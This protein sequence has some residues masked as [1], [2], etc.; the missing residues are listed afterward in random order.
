MTT[1]VGSTEREI[2]QYDLFL[3]SCRNFMRTC[4][5]GPLTARILEIKLKYVNYGTRWLITSDLRIGEIYRVG[6]LLKIS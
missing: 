4:R 1:F 6:M 2:Q 5:H 3:S